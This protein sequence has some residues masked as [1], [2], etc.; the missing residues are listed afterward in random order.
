MQL[1]NLALPFDLPAAPAAAPLASTNGAGALTPADQTTD[2]FND[3]LVS[4]EGAPQPA[5]SAAS[6]AGE[7]APVDAPPAGAIPGAEP[8]LLSL[9]PRRSQVTSEQEETA[10]AAAAA[11]LGLLGL[12]PPPANTPSAPAETELASDSVEM[13]E[14]ETDAGSEV[15]TLAL[16]SAPAAPVAAPK[17][18]SS[19]APPISAPGKTRATANVVKQAATSEAVAGSASAAPQPRATANKTATAAGPTSVPPSTAESPSPAKSDSAREETAAAQSVAANAATVFPVGQNTTVADAAAS[20]S[21]TS[22]TSTAPAISPRSEASPRPEEVQTPSPTKPF[23]AGNREDQE[24]VATEADAAAATPD[25]TPVSDLRALPPVVRAFVPPAARVAAPAEIEASVTSVEDVIASTD[26]SPG[27]KP[28][29]AKTDPAIKNSNTPSVPAAA[30]A[31]T[32]RPQPTAKFSPPTLSSD[33]AP[34]PVEEPAEKNRLHSDKQNVKDSMESLGINVAKPESLMPASAFPAHLSLSEVARPTAVAALEPNG[35]QSGHSTPEAEVAVAARRSVESA[36]EV[37]R[38]F[39]S[40]D[41][42]SVTLQFS[43]SGVDLGVRVELRGDEVHTT[44]RTDSTELRTALAQQWQSVTAAQGG[45][46]AARLAEPVF[47]SNHPSHQTGADAGA[48]NHRE[49]QSRQQ[50]WFAEAGVAPRALGRNK[51]SLGA[52]PPAV[53]A[54]IVSVPGRLH[55]FA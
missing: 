17:D 43:V 29:D 13:K 3:L 12:T 33:I 54:P 2:A 38:H 19:P 15:A 47:T 26:A 45:D 55:T 11:W 9:P 42:R 25:E 50:P 21:L 20:T 36:V 8:R 14:G 5:A 10:G 24:P 32:P 53:R 7:T 28:R 31:T 49:S 39:A 52:P 35:F 41:R 6:P 51:T 16:E 1:S 22:R 18:S 30:I 44:F 34:G 23:V 46:R 40:G 27:A 4:A 37:A 48:A